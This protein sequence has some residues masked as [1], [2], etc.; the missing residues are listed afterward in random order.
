MLLDPT[1]LP[2]LVTK[3]AEQ[4]NNGDTAWLLAS[5]AMVMIMTPAVGFFYGGMVRRHN[6]LATMMQ[7]F[8]VV[9]VIGVQWI[10][11]GYSLAFGPDH[12]HFIGGLDWFGLRNVGLDPNPDYG[13]TVPHQ[14][15]MI[16]QGMFAIITP[17]L[18]TGAFAERMKFSAFL[19]FTVLWATLVYD[20]VAHWV[21]GMDGWLRNMGALDFAG[22]LVV[23]IN[24]GAAALAA[25][26]VMGKRLGYG[27]EPIEAH[28]NA[29]IILGAG[30]LWFGWFGFNAGSAISS[31]GL[32][33][34]AFVVT[35][36]SAAMGALTWMTI[37]WWQTGKASVVGAATGAVVALAAITPAAG[38]VDP[39]VA[40]IIGAGAGVFCYLAMRLRAKLGFD[41]SL[42]V[43]AGHGIGS[44]WGVLA[45]G[46]FATVAVN[47][48]GANGLFNGNPGQLLI[49]LV[50]VMAVWVFSF[51][52][53][54]AIMKVLDKL[55]GLRVNEEAEA[56]GLDLSEHGEEAYQL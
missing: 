15:F 47:A 34:S 17:A 51:G 31:G 13:P 5:A 27:K 42:D 10:L 43:W 38:F 11:W 30:L 33:T 1:Y 32:A 7:S 37:S 21:W 3:A 35:N 56:V 26:L 54:V 4:V 41:D 14:A 29:F 36:S 53:T 46:L 49:Q 45:A 9:A 23:H 22:G 50:A 8:I 39:M 25:A 40:I 48:N 18:I 19:L 52:M 28:N 24:A 16:F 55:V 44:T 2:G 6:A 20:P 12:G